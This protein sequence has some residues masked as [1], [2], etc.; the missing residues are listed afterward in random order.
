M[1]FLGRPL[2][3]T[4]RMASRASLPY[5]GDWVIGFTLA[6]DS[7]VLTVPSGIPK[8]SA[9]SATVKPSIL[10]FIDMIEKYIKIS[11][12]YATFCLDEIVHTCYIIFK[13]N[14]A[15]LARCF[16]TANRARRHRYQRWI[17]ASIY[18]RTARMSEALSTRRIPEG[19]P[20]YVADS[21]HPAST[22]P[23][24]PGSFFSR[25]KQTTYSIGIAAE[26]RLWAY[27][28]TSSSLKICSSFLRVLSVGFAVRGFSSF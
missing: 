4:L 21:S 19:M 1:G 28:V 16:C 22:I 18:E 13:T 17:T 11:C 3:G 7:L 8:I 2:P 10:L 15:L 24:L 27:I 20:V 26:S 23:S 25:G 6:L 5:S 12:I 14:R 9:I